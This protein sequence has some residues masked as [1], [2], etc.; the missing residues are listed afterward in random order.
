MQNITVDGITYRV[1]VVPDTIKRLA[2]L[3]EGPTKGDMLND[4]HE[5]DLTG[6]KLTYQMQI[7]PD[8]V[9]YADYDSL[10]AQLASPTNTHSVTMPFGQSTITFDAMIQSVND[11]LIG[12]A[13]GVNRWHGMTVRFIPVAPQWEAE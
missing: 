7:E 4:R 9:N 2:E 13:L 11:G 1:H 6:T 12:N 5:R 10:F 8:W 3:I